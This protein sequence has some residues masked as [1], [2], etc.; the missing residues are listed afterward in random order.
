VRN[1]GVPLNN[2]AQGSGKAAGI[3][4]GRRVQGRKTVR[5]V[6][7]IR[8]FAE[9]VEALSKR[10]LPRFCALQ[11]SGGWHR[12]NSIPAVRP[13]PR[14]GTGSEWPCSFARGRKRRG[15]TRARNLLQGSEAFAFQR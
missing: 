3:R 8:S 4:E 13:R 14:A 2:E 7:A 11:P 5:T 6:A 1:R 15:Q 12:A 10:F 9:E